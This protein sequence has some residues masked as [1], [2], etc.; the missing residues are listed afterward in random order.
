MLVPAVCLQLCK[1]ACF[2]NIRLELCVPSDL[3]RVFPFLQEKKEERNY[4]LSVLK[5]LPL[6]SPP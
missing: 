6:P 5:D 4:F 2:T 1:A 3:L